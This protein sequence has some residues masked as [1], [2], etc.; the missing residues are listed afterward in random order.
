MP[1]EFDREKP[2][3][4]TRKHGVSLKEAT[5]IW[6]VA[7][8]EIAART[9]DEPRSMVIGAIGGKLYACIYTMRGEAVR[10]ISCRRARGKEVELYHAYFK[11]QSKQ[12]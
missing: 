8:L 3:A 9:I 1:F 10:L 7:H 5:R 12:G 6:E 2:E 11:E 4:N